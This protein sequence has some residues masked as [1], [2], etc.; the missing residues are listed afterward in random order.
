MKKIKVSFVLLAL[1]F[2]FTSIGHAVE[3]FEGVWRAFDGK[4]SQLEGVILGTGVMYSPSIYEGVDDGVTVIPIMIGKY[5]NFYFKGTTL[6][7]V[8]NDNEDVHISLIA[9]PRF[10]G[11]HSDD[12]DVLTGM[13]DRES[14]IDGGVKISWNNDWFLLN[15]TGLT[16]LSGKHDGHEVKVVASRDFLKGGF[17]PRIGAKWQSDNMVEY[18]YG[19]AGAEVRA[20]RPSYAGDAVVNAIAG[21]AIGIPLGDHWTITGDFEY[22]WFGSKI[23]NSPLVDED[24]TLKTMM[25]IVYRF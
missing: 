3:L 20:G 23:T 13:E 1:V 10:S 4:F 22:E 7:Y 9:Q 16:D 6:G 11:Y 18:Y 2:S 25:G 8:V 21:F 5:K 19:V 14:S 12:S 17:T 15:V 24:S